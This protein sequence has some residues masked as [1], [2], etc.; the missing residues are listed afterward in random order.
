MDME[1]DKVRVWQDLAELLLK[2][3]KKVYIK[4][5]YDNLYFA[6][7]LLVGESTITINCFAPSS[8]VGKNFTLYWVTIER[9]EEYKN[10]NRN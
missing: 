6:D 4:D 10:E 5:H 7:I 9:L 3:N 2:E 1:K 8:R